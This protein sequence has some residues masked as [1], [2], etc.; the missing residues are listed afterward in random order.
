M[1]MGRCHIKER[2]DDQ[3]QNTLDHIPIENSAFNKG[4]IYEIGWYISELLAKINIMV[5]HIFAE[6]AKVLQQFER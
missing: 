1:S 6:S 3:V 5:E 4:S 2:L